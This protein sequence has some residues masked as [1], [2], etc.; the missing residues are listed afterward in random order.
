MKE[1]EEAPGPNHWA[2][3]AVMRFVL[4]CIVFMGHL[5]GLGIGGS[6]TERGVDYGELAA[7][8]GFFAI[9][10]FSI[11]NSISI[12]PERYILRR[13]WRIWPTYLFVFFFI[14]LPVAWLLEKNHV[15]YFNNIAV[16]KGIVIGNLFMLQGLVV[17]AMETNTSTWTLAMEEFYYLLAPLFRKSPG[18]VLALITGISATSYALA[19]DF[20]WIRFA[21]LTHGIAH[22]CFLWAWLLGFFFYR[23]R[24]SILAQMILLLLPVW[25]FCGWNELGGRWAVFTLLA[26]TWVI[27]SGDK[28]DLAMQRLP[29]VLVEIEYASGKFWN[30]EVAHLRRWMVF[31]GNVSYPLYILHLPVAYAIRLT[32]CSNWFVYFLAVLA[33]S[34]VVYLFVDKPNRGRWQT[35]KDKADPLVAQ[36]LASEGLA[37]QQA[38]KTPGTPGVG[39]IG[40]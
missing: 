38:A 20:G 40:V 36:I 10:G 18:I 22:L 19:R 30:I 28:I 35:K 7:V 39:T 1:R 31:L 33:V 21:G 6:F 34:L 4:S 3:L 9:S 23:Y 5:S 13:L 12:R 24:K 27:A 16:T 8:V 32:G 2:C 14:T 11:A 26:A 17:T 15:Q 37:D 29:R 25:L